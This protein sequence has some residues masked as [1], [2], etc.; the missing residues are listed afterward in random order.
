VLTERARTD[1][2]TVF[3]PIKNGPQNV[4]ADLEA[5]ME[6]GADSVAVRR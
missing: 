5:W 6:E 4:P 2:G 1:S 3:G